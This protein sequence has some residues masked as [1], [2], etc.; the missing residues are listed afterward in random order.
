MKLDSGGG[1]SP[2]H[3]IGGEIQTSQQRKSTTLPNTFTVRLIHY[4]GLS[5]DEPL[6]VGTANKYADCIRR[7]NMILG[8]DLSNYSGKPSADTLRTLRNKYDLRRAI[9]ACEFPDF[10]TAQA[11]SCEIA[12]IDYDA[13][14]YLYNRVDYPSQLDAVRSQLS[15]YPPL[16]LWLDIEDET[17]SLPSVDQITQIL[18]QA[19][20]DYV[21]GIYTS[22]GY[23]SLVNG[24]EL[25]AS[26]P[27]WLARWTNTPPVEPSGWDAGFGGWV[28]SPVVQYAGNLTLEGVALDLDAW[29]S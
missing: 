12:G 15:L 1:G 10:Y 16:N 25:G 23:W 29:S 8:Y 13:Y 5:T 18:A 24:P 26:C 6:L 28:R 7:D 2:V 3:V 9:L 17:A 27:L 20:A 11:E 21:T 22:A 19:Q 14:L 4:R